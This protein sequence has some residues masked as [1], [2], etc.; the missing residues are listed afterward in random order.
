MQKVYPAANMETFQAGMGI[1]TKDRAEDPDAD[2]DMVWWG[3][4]YPQLFI[5]PTNGFFV[6]DNQ[7]Y[8]NSAISAG[9][10]ENRAIK[11]GYFPSRAAQLKA[12]DVVQKIASQ[13]QPH[14]GS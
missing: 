8:I 9:F 5:S 14:E 2:I 4:K 10:P 12:V 13:F 7:T 1:F 11:C 6:D 3:T